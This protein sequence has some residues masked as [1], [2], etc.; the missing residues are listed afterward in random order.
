MQMQEFD[1]EQWPRNPRLYRDSLHI[2]EH[3]S[4]SSRRQLTRERLE[5]A[6]KE[7]K[8]IPAPSDGND[9][10]CAFVYDEDGVEFFV[11]T[12]YDERTDMFKYV[13]AWPVMRDVR[14]ALA[15]GTWTNNQVWEILGLNQEK[16][17]EIHAGV[18]DPVFARWIDESPL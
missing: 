8:R 16:A 1:P 9:P 5:R 7:G 13:T 2:K 6:V 12:D 4:R 14:R 15:S 3:L 18:G 11:I 17:E 10:N